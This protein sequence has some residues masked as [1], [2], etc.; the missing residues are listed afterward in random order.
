MNKKAEYFIPGF[1]DKIK[2]IKENDKR[3]ELN[4]TQT[5]TDFPVVEETTATI[6]E[7]AEST[8]ETITS[9]PSFMNSSENEEA[10]R[11]S[12]SVVPRVK[13]ISVV[14]FALINFLTVSRAPSCNSVAC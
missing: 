11:L 7:V 3:E 2:E 8:A 10:T 4:V 13:T 1:E 5:E 9:S 14:D 6:E 12:P